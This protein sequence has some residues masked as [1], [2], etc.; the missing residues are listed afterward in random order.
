MPWKETCAL[1]ERVEF[2]L[3]VSKREESIA[4]LCRRFGIARK[5]GYKWLERYRSE[6]M[7]GLED[8]PRAPQH[9]P[10]A[11]TPEVRD[12]I[13]EL[14]AKHP[15]WGPR[16]L[17]ARLAMT[18]AALSI[19]APSTIGNL[20]KASGLTVP[21]RKH[22]FA[23]PRSRPLAHA[24]AANSVWCADFKGD[25]SLGNGIRCFPL[26]ISDAYS[27]YL[28]RCQTLEST[29]T[30]LVQPLF[31]ATFREFG[32]PEVIR[33]DNGPPFASTGVGGLTA[34][35]VW[36]VK[37]G[38]RPER[39]DPG[40]P[41]QNGRHERLHRTLK[42][43]ACQP[44]AYSPRSQQERFDNFRHSYNQERPHEA[45]GQRPP[46]SV[47]IPSWRPFPVR[48]PE[49]TYPDADV[50]RWVRPNGAVR[51]KS[52]EVY[53]GQVLA[54]EPVG[55]TQV[56]DELWEV[57]FGPLLLG[58]FKP[59]MSRLLPPPQRRRDLSPMSPV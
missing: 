39:I 18:H 11:L 46:A 8:R 1:S 32:I 57:A 6:G 27:R 40:K 52:R 51:W 47:Y 7:R 23:P 30:K 21:R 12:A 26:T 2:V 5:T 33:V 17:A 9:S 35:S 22:R 50:T 56:D 36:W 42:Q 25:F 19:P 59:G 29:T 58:S 43:D 34:L 31:E 28:L 48:L 44:P 49:L 37:V 3:A 54:G 24:T 41:Q 45:L 38:I 15:T 20:L 10:H 13:L 55:L 4:E 14:R 16:K 53:V